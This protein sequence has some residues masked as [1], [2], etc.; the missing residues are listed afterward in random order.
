MV[1][2]RG[3][4]AI[5]NTF[6]LITM[7][8]INVAFSRFSEFDFLFWNFYVVTLTYYLLVTSAT[9]IGGTRAKRGKMHC[10]VHQEYIRP[11]V[12]KS[13]LRLFLRVMAMMGK[14]VESV[15]TGYR[16]NM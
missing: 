11:S 1:K 4:F 7:T 15:M 12:R 13:A 2:G 5:L 8:V 14:L 16:L 6:A 9:E 10:L 3:I